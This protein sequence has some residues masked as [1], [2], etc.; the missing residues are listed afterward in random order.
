MTRIAEELEFTKAGAIKL[1]AKEGIEKNLRHK[2]SL[3]SCR[4][5]AELPDEQKSLT[6]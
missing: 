3:R 4:F 6:V 5:S 1:C 2:K